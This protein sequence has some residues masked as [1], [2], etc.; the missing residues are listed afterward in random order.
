[1]SVGFTESVVEE[2]ALEWFAELGYSTLAGPEIA[3]G[4]LLAE[5]DS[6]ADVVLVKRLL[7]ALYSLNPNLPTE[8]IDDALRKITRSE[9]P[10]LIANNRA[11]HR[12]RVDGIEVEYRRV[13]GSIAGDRVLLID[14]EANDWLAVN[15]FTVIEGQHNRRPDVIV[16]LNGLPIA[17]VELKNAAGEDATAYNAF[18]DIETYKLQIPSLFLNN[19]VL[20]VS[21]GL[22]ARAGTISADWERFMPWRT[23]EGE[24]LASPVMPQLEVLLR[25]MFEKRRFL[26]LLRYF[27]VFEEDESGEV[28]KKMAGYH[29]F[30]AVNKAVEATLR[31]VLGDRDEA[32]HP[33]AAHPQ[34][35]HPQATHPLPSPLPKGEGAKRKSRQYRGGYQFAGLVER[36]RELRKKQTPA[37]A[38]LWELL[39]NRQLLGFKFRRQH[40]FGDYIA[41]FYCHE[42]QLVIECDGS[43]HNPNEAWHHDQERDAYM[44]AQGLRVLRFSN[45]RILTDTENVLDEIASY[46]PLPLGEGR[47]EGLQTGP[48]PI[49]DLPPSTFGGGVGGGGAEHEGVELPKHSGQIGVIWHTQGSG[50]SL[51]MAFYAGRIVLHPA[52]QNP[53]I[54]VITD[55]NDLDDQLFGTF[56]RCHEL[57]RQRPVQAESRDDLQRK[58]QVASGG[59]VF[60]TVQKFFP[61]QKG[62][63]YPTLSERRNIVV[64]AD[65]AHRTQYD[66]VDGF[67]RHMRDAL[68]NA[69][70][71]GFTGTPIELKDANTRAVFGDYIS[72]YDIQRAVEDKATVP[73]FYESRLAKPALDANE[74]PHLDEDFEEATEGEEV[75]QKERLKGKWA[76]LEAVVGTDKRVALIADDLVRHW[77][78]RLEAIDGKAMIV[79]MSRRICFD[80]Y[81]AIRKLRPNWH[82]DD[83]TKGVMKIVMTGA[84]SDPLEW[85]AHIRGKKKRR[86]LADRFKDPADP[87]KIVIVRDMWLTGFDVPCLHTMYA[88]KPMRGHGLMQAIARVNRVFKDKLGG[89]VVDYLGLPHELKKALANY[90]ESGGKGQTA[91]DQEEAVE[92][93]LT[94]YEI[95][96]DLF[97]GFD[98]SVWISGTPAQKLSLLPPAQEHILKQEEGKERLLRSVTELTQAFALAVPHSEAIRI[99]DDV[100]FFQ[101]VRAAIAKTPSDRQKKVEDVNFALRQILSR[102]V[103]SDEVLDIFAAAGLKKP[104]ISILSEEFLAEVREMPQKNLAVELLRKL[105][106][107][108]LK[109]RTKKNLVQSRLFSEMLEKAI[110]KYQNRAI[111]TAA[112][113]QELIDL[114]RDMREAEKRG[115]ELGLNEDE[116][117]FYDALGVNDSAVRVLGDE[118]LTTIAREL[119]EMVRRNATIDWTVKESVRARLRIMVKRIL[120]K[121]GYPPDKQ[122]SAT[123]TVLEQAELLCGEWAA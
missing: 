98:W 28:I 30:H 24:E 118:T 34:A 51:T 58:L 13:D 57:L 19:E 59:I 102:A 85:Q 29:Q 36:A 105:L 108:E 113:I 68:P 99:R 20:I 104:D 3:P 76:A 95:C 52:M 42:A 78:A 109:L 107:N 31:A 12:M 110:I 37:E 96:R 44:I 81:E 65:E 75:E 54:V 66:F 61:E 70:F 64:I 25:G 11:L 117:A 55:R 18:K 35:T 103:A 10:S 46:L 6:F 79:C 121:Y 17:T 111:E 53:T 101:A 86:D 14:S 56:S 94:K 32:A 1:M 26:D 67:A 106:N 83:D 2:A 45:E 77:E 69:S 39:R 123:Q 27:I 48:E 88:N 115:E 89:L 43:A 38:F 84:K 9:A 40:Q 47:G 41:D 22:E 33:Q 114:A 72:V 87:F 119:V 100:G 63:V 16:F 74:K 7:G 50:K 73:I 80:L 112:V 97:Y 62:L 93:M 82:D 122:E 8:A 90:T 116:K 60:T 15:Q 91:I 120:R 4:E 92:V 21:D 49:N 5:R 71:I 23:I